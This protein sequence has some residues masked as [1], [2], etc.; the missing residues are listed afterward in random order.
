MRKQKSYTSI[1]KKFYSTIQIINVQKSKNNV[2]VAPIPILN[3]ATFMKQNCFKH[4]VLILGKEP[5]TQAFNRVQD[6]K[7]RTI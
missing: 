4:S 6:I 3:L 5:P 1:R 2:I 7:R